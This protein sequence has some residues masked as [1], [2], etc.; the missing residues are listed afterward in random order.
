MNIVHLLKYVFNFRLIIP[1]EIPYRS[2][3]TTRSTEYIELSKRS[4]LE[5]KRQTTNWQIMSHHFQYAVCTSPRPIC[6]LSLEATVCIL[7]TPSHI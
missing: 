6:P 2:I 4:N 3:T 1:L 5:H 7:S